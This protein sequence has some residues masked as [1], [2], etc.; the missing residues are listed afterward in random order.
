LAA[1]GSISNSPTISIGAT[2][3]FDVSAFAD[4]VFGSTT[5]TASGTTSSA[6]S[7]NGGTTVDFGSQSVSLSFTPTSFTGDTAHPALVVANGALN[8]NGNTFTVNNAGASPLGAGT[9]TL[10]SVTGGTINGTA[11]AAIASV[12][13][14]GMVAGATA[15]ISVSGGVVSLVVLETPAFTN[16]VASPSMVYGTPSVT[17]T[18][19]VSAAGPLYPTN[20][21]T[22]TVTINGVLQSTTV[23]DSTGDFSII[24]TAPTLPYSVSAY[25]ITYSYGGDAL[26]NPVSNSA[27]G[28]TVNRAAVTVTANP[29]SKTYGQ[30]VAFGGGSAQFSTT[31][32]QNGETIGAVTL[33][34]SGGISNAPVSGSPYT[35]IPS[36]AVGGSGTEADYIITYVTNGL[37]INPLAVALAGSE[38]YDGTNVVTNTTLTV[39]NAVVGDDVNVASG[40]STMSS[41]D[42]GTNAL[43]LPGALVLGGTTAGN[44][45]LSGATGSVIVTP[46]AV[47]LTGTRP[48]DGSNDAS[49]TILTIVTNYDGTNLTL[50]G[51]GLL[52]GSA[53]GLEGISSFAGLSLAGSAST[54]YTLSNATGSVTITA[55]ATSFS[56]LT[57]SQSIIYATPSITVSGTVS[58]AGLYPAMGETI[59]VTINGSGQTTPI[60]DT[61]GDFSLIY[62]TSTL[63]V[64]GSP[65]TIAYSY[66][67]DPS[68]TNASDASTTLTVTP[69]AVVLTGAEPYNGT[70]TAAFGY[71]TIIN[72]SNSD[73]V[74]LTSGAANL[75]GAGV[76]LEAILSPGT[77]VLGGLNAGNYTLTGASGSV[78]VGVVPLTITANPQSKTYGQTITFGSGSTQFGSSGLQPGDTIGS[79][80]LACS[81]GVS[82]ASV[83]GSPYLITPSAATGGTFNPANYNPIT[84]VTNGLTVNPLA[85]VLT[86]TQVYNGTNTVTN[87]TL[88]VANAVGGDDVNV[89]SGATTMA[90]A[91]IGTNALSLPGALVLGGTTA[92]NY[93][94]SGAT[95]AVIVTPLAVILTGTRAYDGTAT[96]AAAILSITDVAGSDDVSL[97][98]GSAALAGAAAGAEAITNASGLVLG[99]TTASNYTITGA[100]GSVTITTVPL[101]IT[102]NPVVKTYGT[103]I[104]LDPT[105]FTV[106]GGP[107]VGSE[108]VT[109]VT[110]T[111]TPGGTAA[112]DPVAV[113]TITPSAATGTGGFAA[114]N[115]NITYATNS[116]TVNALTVVLT[117]SR[118]YDGTATAAS[119]ILAVANKVGSDDVNLA[120]GS[121][122]LAGSSVGA[123]GISSTG[124]L[125][126]GGV[127]AGNYTLVG[128]SGTVTIVNP[129]NPFSITSS[130]L[131]LTGTNVVICWQSVPGVVYN[132][133]T[134]TS[135]AP[136]QAWAPAG[137]PI[138]ATNTTTC[139]TLPV[140]GGNTNAFVVIKQ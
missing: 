73:V 97:A 57:A 99:G 85:V 132:V 113:D 82:N 103:P 55:A 93:T 44:Y 116:L 58:A 78:T 43:S 136:P 121:A 114:G 6:A 2:A 128:A 24:Y 40:S 72:A 108:S 25:P 28:L 95:G 76:G 126:L 81:G 5:L 118:A 106:S 139:V 94:L 31:P 65:Y 12:G 107:L 47:T 125:V 67:G 92:G 39:A 112:T 21:E 62:T 104:T 51:T 18:G 138:T 49:A 87:T 8:L 60:S 129:F 59:T 80:T 131:D 42:S 15:T 1:T 98:S 133:L 79:V 75:A 46:L 9:Y 53:G 35:I 74:T 63:P 120:S 71:L 77:L 105:A 68:F 140:A 115:Y 137:S 119:A 61:N 56:G 124:T 110:M 91:D 134:N 111:A 101:T 30:T 41:A 66:A 17:L 70:P 69:L 96:A 84:Y 36:G 20:G 29:Q 127:T 86:G 34:C 100:S 13:G 54:N 7:I 45:T 26:L 37:T 64:G 50:S 4:Y 16:L 32:M 130:S 102:A 48:Y 22:I 38:S 3:T 11:N 83:S 88:S 14:S 123:Q 135:L 33:T 52:A 90:S 27:T 19:T 10:L 117:G 109:N 122:T 23:T 89:A